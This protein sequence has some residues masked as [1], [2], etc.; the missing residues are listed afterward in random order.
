MLTF[1]R[2]CFA[3]K[4]PSEVSHASFWQRYFYQIHQLERDEQRKAELMRRAEDAQEELE[5][6]DDG[7]RGPDQTGRRAEEGGCY[8]EGLQGLDVPCG[9]RSVSGY[10]EKTFF[11]M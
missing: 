4:V 9:G 2:L 7:K 10:S 1:S 3:F 11:I 8:G 5:W 6:D